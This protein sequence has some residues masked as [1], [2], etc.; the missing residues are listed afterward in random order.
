MS[1]S[2][3][4]NASSLSTPVPIREDS[5]PPRSLFE[6][7]H[8]RSTDLLPWSNRSRRSFRINVTLVHDPSINIHCSQNAVNLLTSRDLDSPSRYIKC[9]F[10]VDLTSGM[11]TPC[12]ELMP[13]FER[14]DAQKREISRKG[15][16]P[17][18]CRACAAWF[19]CEALLRRRS[20]LACLCVALAHLRT[21]SRHLSTRYEWAS[22]GTSRF[23]HLDPEQSDLGGAL[24]SPTARRQQQNPACTSAVVFSVCDPRTGPEAGR[25]FGTVASAVETTRAWL[26][27]PTCRRQRSMVR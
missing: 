26:D 24:G 20:T 12:P 1:P 16:R 18:R 2:S 21:A 17:T 5:L 7:I 9:Q 27:S 3:S 13:T 25:D 19:V 8:R 15:T 22:S 6:T 10:T 23:V 11:E 4:A 14:D